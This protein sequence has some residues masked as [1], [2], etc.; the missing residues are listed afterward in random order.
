M[1]TVTAAQ[2]TR[3]MKKYL[4]FISFSHQSKKMFI[5]ATFS[6]VHYL[7]LFLFP[8]FFPFFNISKRRLKEFNFYCPMVIKLTTKRYSNLKK[9]LFEYY[10]VFLPSFAKNL[11]RPALICVKLGIL[12]E[13]SYQYLINCFRRTDNV[14]LSFFSL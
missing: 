10:F 3:I 1:T 11:M 4:K 7:Y 12:G 5:P 9:H 2:I 14:C 6:L 8:L 13:C